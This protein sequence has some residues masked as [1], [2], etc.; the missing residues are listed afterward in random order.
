MLA[1]TIVSRRA[2][3][4][5]AEAI[6][7]QLATAPARHGSDRHSY[8]ALKSHC[9]A[10]WRRARR[11]GA[12]PDEDAERRRSSRVRLVPALAAD[13]EEPPPFLGIEARTMRSS[14]RAGRPRTRTGRNR[15]AGVSLTLTRE[16]SPLTALAGASAGELSSRAT[17]LLA[18]I[19]WPGKPGTAAAT[20][21]TP[22]EQARFDAGRVLYQNICLPCHQANGRGLEGIAQPLVGSEFAL[23]PPAIPIRIL[24]G[25]KEGSTG[26]MPP[27]GASLSDEQIADVLTYI[28]REWGQ[29]GS[30]VDPALV[31]P[32][33]A[34]TAG[35]PDHGLTTSWRNW[36]DGTDEAPRV[37]PPTALEPSPILPAADRYCSAEVTCRERTF[38]SDWMW[39]HPASRP[40][41]RHVTMT[42]AS[43][44]SA[45]GL[46]THMACAA[47]SRKRRRCGRF[48]PRGDPW[49]GAD[50]R[51]PR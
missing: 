47:G 25:G 3:A 32:V 23:G 30:P 48:D 9:S 28:R 19:E 21:L 40:L 20:P 2:G 11:R 7:T 45:S 10:T 13:R 31:T 4:G 24:L 8:A 29:S 15:G 1:A 41:R 17:A 16:P 33:R 36:L 43:T 5:G 34:E 26:L 44:C 46:R 6:S 18:R 27:L 35:R 37:S 49:R 51:S 12:H 39:G 38:W 22:A 42:A 50:C 14:K